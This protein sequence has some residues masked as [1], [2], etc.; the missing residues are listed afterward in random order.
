MKRFKKIYVEITNICNLSCSFCSNDN[1]LKREMSLSEFEIVLKNI[2]DYTDYIYLHVK[3]EPLIHSKLKDILLLCKKY[4]IKVNITTNGMLLGKKLNILLE[5]KVVRQVNISL[6]SY[7]NIK[8]DEYIDDVLYSTMK[9]SENGIYTVLRFWALVG[10]KFS[11][12]NIYLIKKIEKFLNV[13]VLEQLKISN[14]FKLGNNIYIS[15]LSLFNWPN[16]ENNINCDNGTCLGLKTH[17][18][19]L[20]DGTV[21]PCCLDS[22]GI[23]D[24]GNIFHKNLNEILSSDRVCNIITNFNNNKKVEQLCKHCNF[25]K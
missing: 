4:G 14:N 2:C 17:I 16:I 9:L 18:G 15:K 24:L 11:K 7:E 19:I 10:N 22:A 5:S 20:S 1:K 8:N 13:N 12:S 3:G 25:Y 6:Q 23:I 21:V